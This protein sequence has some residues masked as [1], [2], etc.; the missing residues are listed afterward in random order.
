MSQDHQYLSW[1]FEAIGTW[2]QIDIQTTSNFRNIEDLKHN[3]YQIISEYN[4][5]YSRFQ[6]DTL[7]S[8]MARAPG[9]YK[10]PNSAKVLVEVYR[11]LY[12]ATGGAFTPLIGDVLIAAGYDATYCLKPQKLQNAL[13]WDDA[14]EYS[15]PNLILK[16]STILDFGAGGKGHLIDIVAEYIEGLN[17]STYAI[18][19]GGDIRCRSGS[20]KP[21]RIGLEDPQDT[22]KILGVASVS[23]QSICGS[24]GNRRKWD[25]YHHIINPNTLVSPKN[26]LATWVVADTTL[27]ADTIAT[28]LFFV[29]PKKLTDTFSFEYA[30][31]RENYELNAS[32]GFPGEFFSN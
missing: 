4:S 22:K 7:V 24:A 18:D 15:F 11:K 16:K 8:E 10:L 27:L 6:P 12:I 23:N 21:L 9:L 3:I 5:V 17:I 30:L 28:A 19:A 1:S 31:V 32:K 2:W 13:E 25:K 20:D 26:I 29:E 14:L